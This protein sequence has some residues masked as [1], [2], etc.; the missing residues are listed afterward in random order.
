MEHSVQ[1]YLERQSTALLRI[2]LR[3][4]LQNQNLDR[5]IILIMLQLLERRQIAERG[6]SALENRIESQDTQLIAAVK[7]MLSS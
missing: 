5:E 1:A 7:K 6:N 4:Q 2:L 3:Q